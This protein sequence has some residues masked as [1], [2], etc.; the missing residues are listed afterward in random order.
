MALQRPHTNDA[1]LHMYHQ[2]VYETERHLLVPQL[3]R[4]SMSEHYAPVAHTHLKSRCS[5]IRAAASMS[6]ELMLNSLP[7]NSPAHQ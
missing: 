7:R 3:V 5:C 1:V 6:C 2:G 4:A